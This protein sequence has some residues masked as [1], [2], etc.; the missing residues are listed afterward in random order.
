MKKLLLSTAILA[1][2]ISS[3]NALV[4]H[5]S[6]NGNGEFTVPAIQAGL[7]N[8]PSF[9]ASYTTET[10]QNGVLDTDNNTLTFAANSIQTTITAN[11][12]QT[13]QNWVFTHNLDLSQSAG[14]V[15]IDS[16]SPTFNAVC[17]AISNSALNQISLNT[18]NQSLLANF[19]NF[20]EVSFAG[21]KSFGNYDVDYEANM[22]L[23]PVPVPAAAWLFGSALMG[24]VIRKKK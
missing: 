1:A 11:L 2:S 17:L 6:I 3:A 24:L 15:S 18:I 21:T 8:L 19:F 23:S 14:T 22:Q 13:Q 12:G 20:E 7:L 4:Q 5:V 9:T 16:C 10:L